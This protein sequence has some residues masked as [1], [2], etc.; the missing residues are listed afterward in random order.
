MTVDVLN[1]AASTTNATSA[2]CIEVE[3]QLAE[4]F[5]TVRSFHWAGYDIGL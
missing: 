1:G 2:R 3:R 4:Q 5:E